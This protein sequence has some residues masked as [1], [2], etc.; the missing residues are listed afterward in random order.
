[1]KFFKKRENLV[2]AIAFM[3][4]FAAI[5]ALFCVLASFFPLGGLIVLFVVPLT[6]MVVALFCKDLH[7][8]IYLGASIPLCILSSFADISSA[9][10]YAIPGLFTGGLFGILLKR[11]APLYINLFACGVIEFLFF[12]LELPI[13]K[14]TMS[15]DMKSGLL[16][17]FR[18]SENEFAT[19]SFFGF[20]ALY[21]MVEMTLISI[22]ALSILPRLGIDKPKENLIHVPAIFASALSISGFIIG[23]FNMEVAFV[24]LA[25]SLFWCIILIKDEFQALS[26][27]YLIASGTI[28]LICFIFFAIGFTYDKTHGLNYLNLFPLGIALIGAIRSLFL[29]RKARSETKILKQ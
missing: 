19:L 26:W 27:V 24:F 4:M 18:L 10:F 22:F 1:M 17:F 7:Y 3:A 16:S 25:Y 14:A 11:K 28:F 20:M 29:L 8:L 6:S 12:L 2:E 15:I 13:I 21:T 23:F 5:N 9:I